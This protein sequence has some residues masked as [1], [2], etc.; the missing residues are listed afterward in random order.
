MR[1]NNY[2][3]PRFIR[4]SS[5]VVLISF[6]FAMCYI[7]N[8]SANMKSSTPL[9]GSLQ[10]LTIKGTVTD[11]GT[12]EPLPGVNV[13]VEGTTTGVITDVQGNY[14][15]EVPNQN[16]VLIF[17][18]IGY[19]TEKLSP[20]G[21]ATLNV[22]LSPDIRNLDEVVVIGYGSVKKKDLTGSVASLKNDE[23]RSVPVP[24]LAQAMQGKLSGVS[25]ISQDG[26]PDASVS[27]R[28]RGGGSISQSNDPLI[29][30]DG[31][32]VSSL[33]DVPS[34][35]VESIDVLKD[36]S[37]TAIYGSRGA[38]GVILVTTKGAKEGRAT[39]TYNSY[40][41]FNTPA[42]YMNDMGPYDYLK[43]VWANAAANGDAYRIPF[44]QL[45]AIGGYTG[46][47]TDGIDAYKN[48]PA[49]D[50]Q[51]KVYKSSMSWNHNLSITGGSEKTK[52]L[53]DINYLTD[54]GMKVNSYAKRANISLKINQKLSDKIDISLDTRYNDANVKDNESVT[55]S[56]GSILS[57][58]YRFRPI[59]TPD[60]LGDL[61]VLKTGNMQNFGKNTLW[62]TYSPYARI[63][64]VDP[65]TITRTLLNTA[66]LNWGIV[67][68]LTYHTD[69]SLSR[70]WGQVKNWSGP[71]T[72]NYI[73]DATGNILY[74]G[75][76]DNYQK[77]DTWGL[78]WSNTLNY[79]VDLGEFHKLNLLLGQEITNSGGT[80]IAIKADHFAA[81]F[82]ED[83][84][85][86]MIN[87]YDQ[88]IPPGGT[89]PIGSSSFSSAV[90]IPVRITSFFGRANYN[91][92]E[93]YLLTFT[94][95][96]DGSSKFSPLHRWGYFPAGAFA[97]RMSEEPFMKQI[98]WLDNLKL[99]VSYGMA[100]NDGISSSLWSQL[101]QAGTDPRLKYPLN[102]QY[103]SYYDLASTTMAN[104]DLKWETTITRN[105]G[106]DFGFFRSRLSGTFEVYWNTTKDLLM[107]TTIPGITGFTSTFAN[108]GQTSNKGIEFSLDANIIKT[109]DWSVTVGG[110]ANF[111]RNNVDNLAPNVT[112]LYG[113]NWASASTY[114][115]ND[116]TLIQGQPVGLVRGL[117]YNGFYTP[118]DFNYSNGVYTLNPNVPDLTNILGVIHGIGA[119]ERPA[120][121]IA[122]P[123]L[124][125]FKDINGDGKIDDKDIIV[126]GDMTPIS[127]GGFNIGVNYKNI[128]FGVFFVWS[129]GNKIYNLNKLATTFGPKEVGV[130][131]N[132]LAIMNNAYKIYDVQNGQLVRLSTP[133]DLNAA[134]K[135][136]S[137][138]LGYNEVVPTSTLAIEDG[139][140]LRLNTLTL[141]YSLPKAL[142][143]KLKIS[144]VRIYGSIYNLLT[145]TGYSGLDPEVNTNQTMAT[146]NLTYPTLGLD[147]GSYPRAR[148]FVVGLNLNF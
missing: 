126:I 28:I 100:G 115:T 9:K 119:T 54:E 113:T 41:K 15:I 116:Y 62:D 89:K 105:A 25:I 86:A 136:A 17:S 106:V 20:T 131:E 73:D 87:Q 40:V 13:V 48:V 46:S 137:L 80:N 84:A 65:L 110:N 4:G 79:N 64:D 33:S 101:W 16:S 43:Y 90:N 111:N 145:I 59:G 144:G 60:I 47:N 148:S 34:D 93:R 18:F 124:P 127:T 30:L 22:S 75:N 61:S 81:N 3:C 38:N 45:Y 92:K 35:Q 142:Y 114:P 50:M 129:Y 29:L 63:S 117:K 98:S 133:D 70:S 143:K 134:N 104:P 27:I 14:K 146:N 135:N 19:L 139:S 141:G 53:F 121:Q 122:Y 58:S 5:K 147:W 138:P 1:T 91:L 69:L 2:S 74:A 32:P 37:S 7:V 49:K 95:R 67:K 96:A 56:N 85:F 11:A 99:R 42:K 44:E 66:S 12:G 57:Y 55:S 94:F 71:V 23:I 118:N 31:I 82:T 8:A 112:G 68:G 26:R 10:L 128:D 109:R 132:K 102:H 39:V 72:N 52:V 36:A 107:Q 97:W 83:N 108:I 6:I 21:Q 76:I 103:T 88:T 51:K 123:G 140:Y 125:K 130:Y 24:N 77:S 120:G 78:R